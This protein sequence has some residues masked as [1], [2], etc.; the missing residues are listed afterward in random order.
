MNAPIR[1]PTSKKISTYI[2]PLEKLPTD[3]KVTVMAITIPKIPKKLPC[4]EVSGDESPLNANINKTPE[5]K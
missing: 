3:K 2:N 5:T 1:P 4:L